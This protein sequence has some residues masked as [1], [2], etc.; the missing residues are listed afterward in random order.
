MKLLL[1]SISALAIFSGSTTIV[2]AQETTGV[3]PI[4]MT[5]YAAKQINRTPTIVRATTNTN[6]I[7]GN[8]RT[9][10]QPGRKSSGSL[11]VED[12]NPF[13]GTGFGRIRQEKTYYDKESGG[14]INQYEYMGLLA[15]RGDTA[16]LQQVQ[17]YLQQNGVYDPAKVQAAIMAATRPQQTTQ[18]TTSMP[19]GTPSARITTAGQQRTFKTKTQTTS[20]PQRLHGG[21][22]DAENKTLDPADAITKT[23][24]RPI[25]L[26]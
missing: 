15:K 7:R 13:E 24:P 12:K 9:Y 21:Y 25:F 3:A 14:H 19:V 16:K 18:S 20:A 23:G 5:P 1:L 22:D 11:F 8:V 6:P 10:T 26:R 2:H 17:H 4:F